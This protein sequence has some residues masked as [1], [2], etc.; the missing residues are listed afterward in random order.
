MTFPDVAGDRSDI[1]SQMIVNVTRFIQSVY[2]VVNRF[3]V[4][5]PRRSQPAAS[6]NF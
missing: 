5:R 4:R 2:S 3:D 1:H 6:A